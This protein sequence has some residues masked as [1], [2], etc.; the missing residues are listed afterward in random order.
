MY[1]PELEGSEVVRIREMQTGRE[2]E[3]GREWSIGGKFA[4]QSEIIELTL[5][6]AWAHLPAFLQQGPSMMPF[7]GG[8]GSGR[9]FAKR[10]SA[11]RTESESC[12]TPQHKWLIAGSTC[13]FTLQMWAFAAL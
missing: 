3:G 1:V 9:S 10:T 4:T 8:Q 7:L 2:E 6:F 11:L 13:R 5:R 12:V